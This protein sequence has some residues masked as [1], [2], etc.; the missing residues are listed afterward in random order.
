MNS[1]TP[2]KADLSLISIGRAGLPHSE[3]VSP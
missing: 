1:E 3:I 2:Q